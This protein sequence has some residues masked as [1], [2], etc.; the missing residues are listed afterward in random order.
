MAHLNEALMHFSEPAN[1]QLT[2][3]HILFPKEEIYVISTIQHYE[4]DRR[5]GEYE[6]KIRFSKTV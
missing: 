3:R 2:C 5:K 4:G 1:T 6:G